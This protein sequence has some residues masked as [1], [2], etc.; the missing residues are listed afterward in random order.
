[1]LSGGGGGDRELRALS[2]VLEEEGRCR[3]SAGASPRPRKPP[4]SF[5]ADRSLAR[6]ALAGFAGWPRQTGGHSAHGDWLEAVHWAGTERLIQ[7][8]DGRG[9][10]M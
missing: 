2:K 7:V 8:E 10:V 5:T 4:A 3:P 6:E 9:E 1:M